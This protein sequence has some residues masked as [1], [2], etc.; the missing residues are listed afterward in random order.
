LKKKWGKSCAK[1]G[2]DPV[3]NLDPG[4]E[5]ELF[6]VGTGTE[7]AINSCGDTTLLVSVRK[8]IDLFN[9]LLW[10]EKFYNVSSI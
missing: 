5:P 7:T 2:L 4:P 6:K 10:V 1:Y 9:S 8:T 3:P